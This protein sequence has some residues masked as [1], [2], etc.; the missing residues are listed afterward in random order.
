M[1]IALLLSFWLGFYV[2]LPLVR[3]H[4]KTFTIP[5]C[6]FVLFVLFGF[7]CSVSCALQN[8][9]LDCSV[10]TWNQAFHIGNNQCVHNG[11]LIFG[12][13]HTW[14]PMC[15]WWMFWVRI[16][17]ILVQPKIIFEKGIMFCFILLWCIFF[18]FNTAT[19]HQVLLTKLEH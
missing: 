3:A 6:S 12:L 9:L 4:Y 15:V 13:Q 7:F 10:Q 11:Q 14:I 1:E 2:I 18:R 17:H 19:A 8:K 16:S 5:L